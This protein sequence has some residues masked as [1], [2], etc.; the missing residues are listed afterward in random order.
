MFIYGKINKDAAKTGGVDKAAEHTNTKNAD[1]VYDNYYIEVNIKKSAVIIY[2]YSK[3]KKTKKPYKVFK[4]SVGSDVKKGNYKIS[5]H[6]SWIDINGGWHKYNTGFDSRSWIQSAEYSDKYDYTLKKSSYRAIGAQQAS[7]KCIMLYARDAQWIYENCKNKTEINIIKGKKSDKL[8]LN[9]EQTVKT[10]KYCGWDP[11]DTDKNNP[12]KK[13]V[14]GKIILGAPTVTVEKG[15]SPNYLNNI[16]ARDENG[17]NIASLLKYKKIDTSNTGTFKVK[18]SYKTK[19]GMKVEAVQ[20]IKVIDTT[21]PRITCSKTLFEYEVDSLDKKDLNKDSNVK[22]IENMV[23]S[24]AS[25]NESG[26]KITVSC[27]SKDELKEGKV[28]VVI[29]GQDSAGNVGSCQVMC[30]ISVKKVKAGK[31]FKPTKDQE[32]ILKKRREQEETENKKKTSKKSSDK[33]EDETIVN[34]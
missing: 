21:P 5:K 7:G 11:T 4:C 29:K 12:Y 28:P 2:E 9:F 31:K 23:R 20:K 19:S 15:D 13:A 16:I 14:N 10:A 8:P 18:Y 26:V 32:E 33:K 30:E 25:S 17:N 6:Y 34:E 27:V 24:Y 1:T 22:A 3:D